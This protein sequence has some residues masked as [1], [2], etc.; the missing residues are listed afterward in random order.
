MVFIVIV[1]LKSFIKCPCPIYL[2][3]Y[4]L[5]IWNAS[6]YYGINIYHPIG[7][8]RWKW[9]LVILICKLCGLIV[10]K[11][12]KSCTQRESATV[13]GCYEPLCTYATCD[14]FSWEN[15]WQAGGVTRWELSKGWRRGITDMVWGI[16]NSTNWLTPKP[17]CL[18]ILTD[19]WDFQVGL[20]GGPAALL[21]SILPSLIVI[22]GATWK[23]HAC[24]APRTGNS[25]GAPGA[26]GRH[27]AT[28]RG[29]LAW[30]YNGARGKQ[31]GAMEGDWLA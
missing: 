6:F 12:F 9:Y 14:I 19:S 23:E 1:V 3:S 18:L 20:W 31:G 17:T 16:G 24:L 21:A 4:Y 13:S 10:H 27:L 8:G 26:V 11:W 25:R 29:E 28:G 15:T 5:L 7:H 22:T 30:E 2:I